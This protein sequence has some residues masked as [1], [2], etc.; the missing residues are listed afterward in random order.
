MEMMW[1]VLSDLCEPQAEVQTVFEGQ[2]TM[3]REIEAYDEAVDKQLGIVGTCQ[4]YS[5][6]SQKW[7]FPEGRGD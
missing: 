1:I 4:L 2:V 6:F 3:L 7:I 5:F